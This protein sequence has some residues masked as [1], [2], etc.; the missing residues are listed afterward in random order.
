MQSLIVSFLAGYVISLSGSI[1]PSNMSAAAMELTIDK[2]KKTGLAFGLGSSIV[3]IIYIRLYFL[4]FDFFIKQETLF[5]VLQW[6]MIGL[7]LVLGIIIF[8]NSFRKL[9]K[10]ERKRKNFKNY[11]PFKAF[12]LGVFLKAINPLQFIFWTF[13]SSYLISNNWLEPNPRHYNWFVVGL[14]AAT[15]T[16]FV[17]YVFLGNY[18]SNQSFFSKKIFK[19]IIAGFLV[20]TSVAW[21][22]KLLI[23]PTGITV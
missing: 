4:G 22:I 10:H 14:G 13:W 5:L 11:T 23:Y 7:F 9:K 15:F 12:M 1:A 8:V 2:N 20:L 17:L 21:G 6:V 16:G 3:E 18:L 19:R